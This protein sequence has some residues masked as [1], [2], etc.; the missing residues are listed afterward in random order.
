MEFNDSDDRSGENNLFVDILIFPCRFCQNFL[1]LK[2]S[3]CFAG[4]MF[5][6]HLAAFNGGHSSEMMSLSYLLLQT[7]CKNLY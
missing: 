6:D 3:H 4:T 2:L 7:C 1:P 5:K